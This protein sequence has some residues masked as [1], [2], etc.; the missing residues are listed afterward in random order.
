MISCRRATELM[1]KRLD[2]RLSLAELVALWYHNFICIGCRHFGRQIKMLREKLLKSYIDRL[3]LDPSE[4]A[5]LAKEAKDR[6]KSELS[7]H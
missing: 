1:S 3:K 5:R 2:A 4:D 7:K 6:I